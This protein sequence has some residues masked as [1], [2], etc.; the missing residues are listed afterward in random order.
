VRTLPKTLAGQV[1]YQIAERDIRTLKI[2]GRGAS[3]TVLKGFCPRLNRFVAI[4]RINMYEQ[5][6]RGRGGFSGSFGG[7]GGCVC[8]APYGFWRDGRQAPPP[9]FPPLRWPLRARR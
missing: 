6:R 3:S 2:L 8:C 7:G 5:A 9:V 4:K 1:S